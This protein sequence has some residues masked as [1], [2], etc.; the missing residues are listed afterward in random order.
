MKIKNPIQGRDYVKVSRKVVLAC[1]TATALLGWSLPVS[2]QV[3]ATDAPVAQPGR[4]LE[5]IVVSARKR[6]ESLDNVPVAVVAISSTELQNNIASDLN[7]V[8]ELAPQVVIGRAVNGT[9]AVL[10]IRGISSSSA[11]SGL[12]QSVAVSVDGVILSRGRVISSAMFDTQQVEILQ[13][14]QALFFGKNSPAGVIAIQTADP[15]NDFEGY[16]RFGYEFEANERIGE[17][18]LSGPLTDTLRA[19]VALR[20]SWMDGWIRNVAKPEANPFQPDAPLPGAT[21]GR[22]SPDGH[23]L[24]G[25]L[26]LIWSPGDDFEAKL[27]FTANEQR[28]N[29]TGAFSESY[30][31]GDTK[32]PVQMGVPMTQA[33]CERNRVKAESTLPPA[34]AINYPYAN[35]GEFYFKS[36]FTLTSLNLTKEFDALTLASTTGYYDQTVQGAHNPDSSEFTQIF[37]TERERY[38]ILTQELRL[39]SDFD[40][41]VNFMIGAYFETADRNWFDAPDVS[42]I[43]NPLAQNYT[44][45]M[46]RTKSS[47][48]SYSAFAQLSW[49]I[50]PTLELSGGAR[51]SRDI[52]QTDLINLVNNPDSPVGRTLYPQGQLLRSRFRDNDVSPEATLTWKPDPDQTIYAAYKSGYKAGGIS[53]AVFLPASA[54]PDNIQFGSEETD[55]FEAGYKASLFNRTLRL[56]LVGYRYNYDGL[57]VTSF[58]PEL[59]RFTI[60]NAASARTTGFTLSAK[61]LANDRLSFNG[62]VGYNRARYLNFA[63]A[64]CYA[65]QTAATGCV[66]GAQDLS[67]KKLN[68]APT[69][70][71]NFGADYRADLFS[72]WTADLAIDASHSSSYTVQ[73]D[74]APGGFQKAFWRLNAAVH[75]SPPD[76]HL[77]LSLI[78]RNLTNSYYMV[79]SFGQSGVGNPEQYTGVFNRPRE[80]LMQASYRF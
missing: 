24:A 52:K 18:M 22:T 50:V 55:G 63:N 32:V 23:D 4:E 70:T 53:N 38:R 43:F 6:A 60:N 15:G 48:E 13:G 78:G 54:T 8:A 3:D 59:I 49:K 56:D 66:N 19:R 62:N 51:Y 73:T 29:A 76:E 45:N 17:M 41:P 7:K 28:L 77:Q 20:G 42:H 9:G 80:V 16:A 44:T 33:D 11:D 36:R 31:V 5:E 26:T 40:G 79:T 27:K 34:F 57:Q 46:Q 75:L 64:P 74:Y 21:N 72:G 71:Y 68:R 61:W 10:T 12:D 47:N 14:P 2:A 69:L 58:N 25:R 67:G 37:I 30:C 35:G 39:S 1:S 65:G